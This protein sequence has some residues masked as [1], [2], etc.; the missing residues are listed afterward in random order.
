MTAAPTLRRDYRPASHQVE[1]LDLRFELG[2]SETLVTATTIFVSS[3]TQDL[4]LHGEDLELRSIAVDGRPLPIDRYRLEAPGLRLLGVPARFTLTTTVAIK[5]QQNT[6]LSGLYASAGTF[7]TQCEAE[8]FRRITYALDR[9]DVMTRFSTEI[10]GP[11]QR[12]P[13]LLSNGNRVA[14]EALPDG[15]HRVRWEDPHPKPTY[16]FAL[17][18]GDL[19]CH[20]GSFTTSSG[21]Q[22]RLE[23]WVEHRNADMC[24]HALESLQHAMRWDEQVFGLEYDLD[25]Y[26]VVAVDDF[27]M[28]AMENKGLNI[29][30]SKYVLA[31]TDT[32][33]DADYEAI[34]AVIA[35]EY[36]HNWTGNRV[37]CRDWFQLTLKEGLTVFRDQ[38]FTAD[39]TSAAV[40]RIDDVRVLR[41]G[42][43]A[44][45]AGPMRHP[46]RPESY[47]VMDNFYTAT[48][49]NK[50]A[51]VIRMYHTLLGAQGF[52][53]GM[54][55][56][57]QR[58]DGQAVTC[59]DFRAAMADANGRDL[60]QFERWYMQSGTPLLRAELRHEADAA[61]LV[62]RQSGP[63][64]PG[65]G[66]YQP[67]HIP[68]R[69]AFLAA[70]GRPI[71]SEHAGRRAHEHV[72][73]LTTAE[74]SFRF[75]Q[76][77]AGGV[78]SLLRGFSAPVRL[79]CRRT[80]AELAL[81]LAHDTD[82]FNRWEA[83]QTY[84][85]ELLLTLV[86][87][88]EAAIPEAFVTAL[89]GIL[90]D[91]GLDDALQA[92]ALALPPERQLALRVGEV[93]PAALHR[94][95]RRLRAHLAQALRQELLA[96]YRARH[97]TVYRVGQA[98]IAARKLK[99]TCLGWLCAAGLAEGAE[100]AA[101]Q[102][103]SASN[104]TDRQAAFACLLDT[105]H[106]ER[107]AA[108]ADFHQRFQQHPL[109]LDKWFATQALA[110]R[111]DTAEQVLRLRE[112]PDFTLANPNR[113]R[114]LLGTFALGNHAHF[115]RADGAGYRILGDA[116]CALSA[117]NPQTAARLVS[118][119]NQW[120]R[121]LP[122]LA[123]L[124][125]QQL[126]RIRAEPGCS[127]DVREI[128]EKALA[129]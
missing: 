66:A 55:L 101:A 78:V 23:I 51:E 112:H 1:A 41:A 16:L 118:G 59:D 83:G 114:S 125:R 113:A 35:H 6:Q 65:K 22:V 82:P 33:T 64:T 89:R 10:I 98:D 21:R 4:L 12:F 109:V 43:F 27:N 63:D 31:R 80:R 100:L 50:G 85:E 87:S 34:E 46:I 58:H 124:Q 95:R 54:D 14:A 92:H 15:R 94:A 116:V 99:N 26:M 20:A 104:M 108:L 69:T 102:Y 49:Y 127:A 42:Q 76:V 126:E 7:C 30:N 90:L 56:Y 74:A 48:V 120:R 37:T 2:E 57:F 5:P 71:E 72:L 128:V 79:E 3:S 75:Q 36:F 122:A 68:V 8:G 40:K 123:A 93:D 11:Q 97:T 119:F 53:A 111:A 38:Q 106:P 70:D 91:T 121:Y 25:I 17:V 129:G 86:A 67:M 107:D 39:R 28:G 18:A 88:P 45:D 110:E 105:D 77:P 29:F 117:R 52:R 60:T 19:H 84:A 24:A 44:E 73:E 103:R 115:H 47:V 96:A 13:V 81:V 9:P 61:V 32:A 62:L